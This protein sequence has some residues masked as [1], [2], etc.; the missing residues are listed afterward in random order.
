MRV[1]VL[2]GPRDVRFEEREEPRITKPTDAVI[3]ISSACVCGSD[4]WLIAAFSLPCNRPRW[5]TST[6]GSLKRSVG[7]S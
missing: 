3:G 6:A 7:R 5:V 1:A 2:Y 4:L